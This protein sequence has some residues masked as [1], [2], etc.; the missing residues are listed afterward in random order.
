M[1]AP[2][3]HRTQF[4]RA[5]LNSGMNRSEQFIGLLWFDTHED[6]GEANPATLLHDLEHAGMAKQNRTR[7][8][9][10]ARKSKRVV[11][12]RSTGKVRLATRFA[13]D[14]ESRYRPLCNAPR[15][16]RVASEFLPK[17]L[18]P[19][20]RAAWVRL[21]DEANGCYAVGYYDGAAVLYRRIVEALLIEVYVA[22]AREG[23][24]KT[25]PSYFMLDPLITYFENDASWARRSRNLVPDLKAVKTVGDMAAHHRYHITQKA[26]LD[27][28]GVAL[29]RCVSEL[30]HLANL[31]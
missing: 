21:C 24:I 20:S 1:P 2:A 22:A 30:V 13:D 3:D 11:K 27:G 15:P 29:R 6:F 4:I 16:P 7:I 10:Q 8:V 19:T 9:E 26:D 31:I 25:G 5:L 14:M 18:L 12:G 23:E 28:L 17:T